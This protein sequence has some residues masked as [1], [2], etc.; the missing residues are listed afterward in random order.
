MT[1]AMSEP[2]FFDAKLS[3]YRSLPPK[4]FFW[5]MAVLA[6]IGC[7][8]G[9]GFVLAGAWPVTGF[10]GLD[11]ALIYLAFRLSYRSARQTE[12]VRLTGTALDVERVGIRGERRAWRFEPV[13]L[14]IVFEEREEGENRLL[15][16][17]HGKSFALGTFL[18]APERRSLALGLKAALETWRHALRHRDV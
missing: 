13:W 10:F 11:V 14:R 9:I 7:C 4:G 17:S 16:A 3:P 15:I 12:K 1:E 5:I 18:S 8:A 6:A 2:I